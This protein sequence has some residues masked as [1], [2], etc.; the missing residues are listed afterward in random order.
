[1]VLTLLVPTAVMA[2]DVPLQ[3]NVDE[4]VISFTVVPGSLGFGT[5]V[6]GASSVVVPF[7][8]TNTGNVKIVVTATISGDTSGFYSAYLTLDG[9]PVTAFTTVTLTP[10]TGNTQSVNAQVHPTA[11][12]W[13]NPVNGSLTFTATMVP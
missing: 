2:V 10:V 4:Q 11:G 1:M 9:H 6:V 13:T 3:T 5:V 12:G 8:I 7:T